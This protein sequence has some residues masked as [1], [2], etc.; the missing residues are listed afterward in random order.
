MEIEDLIRNL[1][2][3]IIQGESGHTPWSRQFVQI[4]LE[5]YTAI[6]KHLKKKRRGR[7]PREE[8]RKAV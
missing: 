7:P 2:S 4:Y 5:E 3:K 6:L 1:E 8:I